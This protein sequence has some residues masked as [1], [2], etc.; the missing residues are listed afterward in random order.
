MASGCDY[1]TGGFGSSFPT[2][3]NT[4]EGTTMAKAIKMSV[5]QAISVGDICTLLCSV[6]SGAFCNED[7]YTSDE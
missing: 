1:S 3:L 6:T 7:K 2:C 4:K 5:A